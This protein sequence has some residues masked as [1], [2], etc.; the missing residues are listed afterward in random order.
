[1]KRHEW[2]T[3]NAQ[4]LRSMR[5]ATAEAQEACRDYLERTGIPLRDFARHIGYAHSTLRLWLKG[6][7]ADVG[8][9]DTH[10]RKAISEFIDTH[11]VGAYAQSTV[12]GEVYETQ[13]MK[14]IRKTFDDLLIR[15]QAQIIYGPPGS[16]KT[17]A[18]ESEVRRFNAQEL[19]KNGTGRRAYYIYARSCTPAQMM[20]R[21]AEACGSRMV[22][23]VDTVIRNLRLE[24]AKRRVL[25]IIDEAQHLSLHCLEVVRELYD[26]PPHFSI[27][28]AGSHSLIQ[29]LERNPAMLEQWNSRIISKLCLPGV[30]CDEARGI[31]KHEV[32]SILAQM[33][34]I[35]AERMTTRLIDSS[36][37]RDPFRNNEPYIN[38]RSLTSALL[39]IQCEHQRRLA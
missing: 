1:M 19:S 3:S 13:H 20:R 38:I 15:P 9:T 18:L 11:A 12:F 5:V 35:K 10:I 6:R 16:Q 31:I 28:L 39:Q 32:G 30:T 7:Y 22:G 36:I 25:L 14:L 27:L 23:D 26:R 2:V 4:N 21:I 37:R 29:M 8:G 33:L 34:P 17:F 24:F